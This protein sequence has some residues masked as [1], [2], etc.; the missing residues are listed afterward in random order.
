M[1]LFETHMHVYPEDD[2]PALLAAAR[3]QQ[4]QKFLLVA[5]S[6]DESI[7]CLALAQPDAQVWSTVGVH[8]H[9][10]DGCNADDVSAFRDLAASAAVVAVGEIGLDYYYEHSARDQQRRVF[11]AFLQLAAELALP[12]VIHCRDAYDDCL[13]ILRERLCPGQLFVIHSVTGDCAWLEAV[14]A[15][16]GFV[17]FNGMVTFK[18]A[19]NIRTLLAAVP[20]ARILLETDSPY[21]APIPHRGKRN[22]PA[23]L[24]LIAQ[25]VAQEK[26]VSFAEL[27]QATTANAM[28]LFL[29]NA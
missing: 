16:G 8:P 13:A 25:R 29:P 15:L 10:A 17:S 23:F 19:D 9:G 20:L 11:A 2:L 27:A 28:R 22:Q 21:L 26:G 1:M 5:G 14:L 12:A 24:P 18:K 6:L 7:A 4:V 3:Q